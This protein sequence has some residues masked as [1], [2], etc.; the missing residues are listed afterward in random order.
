MSSFLVDYDQIVT[1]RVVFRVKAKSFAE[2]EQL[3][4][5]GDIDKMELVEGDLV[6]NADEFDLRYIQNEHTGEERAY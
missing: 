2:V 6:E 3:A 1:R 5:N 4:A